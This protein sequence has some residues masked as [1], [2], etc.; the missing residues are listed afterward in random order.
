MTTQVLAAN[1][2]TDCEAVIRY[3]PECGAPEPSAEHM[4]AEVKQLQ[5]RVGQLTSKLED[6]QPELTGNIYSSPPS[7]MPVI[8]SAEEDAIAPE[9]R[10]LI[11]SADLLLDA[12]G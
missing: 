7:W 6:A 8:P 1:E 12:I 3:C 9:D 11:E 4:I 10:S 2:C 5:D